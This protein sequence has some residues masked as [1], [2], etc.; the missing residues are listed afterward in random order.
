M[1]VCPPDLAASAD[2]IV[3]LAI[4]R[5]LAVLRARDRAGEGVEPP[6]ASYLWKV[7]YTTTIDEL[8]KMQSRER[9]RD[10]ATGVVGPV[11]VPTPDGA[12]AASEVS[13]A[14][15][16]CLGALHEDRRRAVVLH[17]QGHTVAETGGLLGWT[18]KRAENLI[19]R[20]L[21]DL[22]RCLGNKGYAP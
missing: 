12:V 15:R 17:L 2:D 18:R 8:R 10:H 13:A 11:E 5:V 6:S 9:T 20:G 14:L 21:A 4:I 1:K 3:Q 16:S 7:A 22:R 19:Y